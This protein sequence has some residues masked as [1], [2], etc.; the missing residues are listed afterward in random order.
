MENKHFSLNFF[1]GKT[2]TK[3][4]FFVCFLIPFYAN[5]QVAL[6]NSFY[7]VI[8]HGDKIDFGTIENG[9]KWIISSTDAK[10]I[11]TYL[12][13]NEINNFVFAKPGTYEIL[14][15]ETQKHTDHECSHPHFKERMMIKVSPIKMT[16]DFSKISFSEQI[17]KG[18]N[19]DQIFV[20]VPVNV[21]MKDVQS[22]KFIVS[23]IMVTGFG[24]EITAKP[25]NTEVILKNGTQLLKYQLSGVANKE[26]YLM[27]DFVD[28]NNNIQTYYQPE[29]VN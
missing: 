23:N 4:L 29:K 1:L 16:F 9:V 11:S 24:S 19:C 28:Y 18:N 12:N 17:K 22:A 25:L 27:F 26:A 8:S 15:S 2:L 10:V 13:D 6:D 7:K 5:C 14:F 20:T 3:M 21:V